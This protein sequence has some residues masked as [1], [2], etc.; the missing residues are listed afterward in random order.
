MKRLA[1][2]W[3]TLLSCSLACS[4]STP[5]ANGGGAAAGGPNPVQLAAGSAGAAQ[6]PAGTGGQ[7]TAGAKPTAAG[8]G[9]RVE[10]G[11]SGGEAN[12]APDAGGGMGGIPATAGMPSRAG[13]TGNGTSLGAIYSGVPLLDTGGALLNAHGPGFIQVAKTFYMVGEQRSGKNDSYTGTTEHAEDTFTGVNLYSTS[14]FVHWKFEGTVVHPIAGTIVAP[15]NYGERPKILYNASTSK[16]VIYIK[17]LNYTN[18]NYAGSYAVLTS[19][20][21]T[22]P[23]SYTG[24]LSLSGADDFQVFQG[25]DGTQ[26]FVRSSGHLYKLS[27]NGLS[28]ASE[29][30]SG[31]QSGEGVSLYQ[32]GDTYFWQSS[33]GSYWKSNDNSYAS[34]SSL[35]GTWSQHGNFCPSGSKTWQSQDTAVIPVTGS[36]G[37]TYVYV[38]DRWVNGALPASTLVMQPLT[39]N[40]S[41]ESIPNYYPAWQLDVAAGTWAAVVPTG[42]SVNDSA[43][44]GGPNQFVYGGD[45]SSGSCTGCFNGDAHSSATA[46]ATA[47]ISFSGTQVLLYS[48][49]SANAGI[50][51]A[52]LDDETG[53]PRTPDLQISLRYDAAAT[54][55]Y[56]V[57]AS[58]VLPKSTYT[59]K[60]RVTGLKDRYSASAS[61]NVDRVLVVP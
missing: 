30:K 24:N 15:P 18:N 45:W 34:A 38:G 11:G 51:T 28:I 55:N 16:F 6:N 2:V 13:G 17:M 14:D 50:M 33:Q 56:L 37:T 40:G 4:S 8:T 41:A 31:I 20:A 44:G 21:I 36:A 57:Y 39:V 29:I 59:L 27:A 43:I 61:V 7:A 23:Y 12:E 22:G 1:I 9:G 10:P 52:T 54:G 25:T 48:A 47:S 49:Y 46:G 19:S 35:T 58:P 60:V 42:A 3:S 5:V 53:A 32:A 26:Y